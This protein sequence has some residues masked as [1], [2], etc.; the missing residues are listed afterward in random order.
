MTEKPDLTL[1]L[2]FVF[3]KKIYSNEQLFNRK[4]KKNNWNTPFSF[5]PVQKVAQK[6]ITTNKNVTCKFCL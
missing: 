2:N 5:L 1:I 3:P 6:I 4:V